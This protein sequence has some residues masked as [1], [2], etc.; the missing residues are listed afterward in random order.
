MRNLG[1][2][3]IVFNGG[4]F[5]GAFSVGFAKSIWKAGIR[6]EVIQG[7]SVGAL[8]AAKIIESGIEAAEQTWL[9]IEKLG[10]KHIFNWKD[11]PMNVA[12]RRSSLFNNYGIKRIVDSIDGGKLIASPTEL[13]I[14]TRNETL[15]WEKETHINHSERFS[16]N[17]ELFKRLILA[18]AALPAGLPPVEVENE[19]HSDGMTYTL[20][21]MIDSQC[22]TIFLLLNDQ[23]EGKQG[24]FDQRLSMVLHKDYEEIVALRLERFLKNHKDFDVIFD[25]DQTGM[26]SVIKRMQAVTRSVKSVVASVTQGADINF[27]PHKVFALHTKKPITTMN[28]FGFSNGDIKAGIEIGEY[29]GDLYLEKF[30]K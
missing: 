17:P 13:Q 19:I 29:Q 30:L 10:P 2:V 9:D 20:K 21:S 1:K 14:V 3:G 27:V 7:V 25:E 23:A 8:T 16:K 28:T 22:D 11:I 6:P 15:D 5:T 18:S 4:G 26:P 12:M 24:R